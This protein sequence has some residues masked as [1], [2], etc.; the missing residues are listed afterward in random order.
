MQIHWTQ[1][2]IDSLI[3]H[4]RNKT[5]DKSWREANFTNKQFAETLEIKH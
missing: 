4:M 1:T 2:H 5:F 3:L